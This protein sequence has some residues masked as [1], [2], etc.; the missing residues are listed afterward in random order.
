MTSSSV[1][2]NGGSGSDDRRKLETLL[3]ISQSLGRE[4]TLPPLLHLIAAEVTAAMQAERC[5]LF[6]VDP[7]RPGELVSRVAIPVEQELRVAFGVGIAGTTAQTQQTINVADAYRDPRFN[8]SF[9]RATGFQTRSLLSAPI[10]DQ[11]GALVGVV[12]VLNRRDGAFSAAD[13]LFLEAICVHLG[14]AIRRAAMVDAL[15]Q[16]RTLLQSL[17]VARE[18]QRGFVPRDFPAVAHPRGVDVFATLKPTYDVGGDLYDFFALDQDRVCFIIGDVS[19]KGIPAALFMAMARTAFK[20][21]AQA[22]R[23]SVAT[24]LEHVN[25]FLYESNPQQLFVT[26]LAGILD[27]RSGRVEYADAGHEPPFLV[28]GAGRARRVEK[29]GGIVLGLLPERTYSAGTIEMQPGDTLVLFTDGVSEAM[30][31]RQEFFGSE[32]TAA[33]LE[34]TPP[35]A[36][37]EALVASLLDR[38]GAFAAGAPQSDDIAVLAIQYRGRD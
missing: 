30:N 6:L 29:E 32:A 27:V 33:A 8:P 1:P 24:V 5:T 31:D 23:G 11:E 35:G 7:E 9:D 3:R 4:V 2:G 38:I 10:L 28:S 26:A 12:Q 14:I 25:Q 15:V 20:I 37:C 13:Q 21:S 19:G 16:A 22:A 34:A 18:I 17:E 36:A